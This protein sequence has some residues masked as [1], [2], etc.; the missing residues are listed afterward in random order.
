MTT[1]TVTVDE[2]RDRLPELLRRAAAG[3]AVVLT[4]GGRWVGQLAPPPPSPEERVTAEAARMATYRAFVRQVL[5]DRE[6]EGAPE[7]VIAPLRA[8]LAEGRAA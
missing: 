2:A 1:V 5:A 4:D 6:Q 3:E 8:A 7:S